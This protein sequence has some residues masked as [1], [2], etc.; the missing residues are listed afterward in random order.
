MKTNLPA[1][2]S[3]TSWIFKAHFKATPTSDWRRLA[4]SFLLS[5]R[6]EEKDLDCRL[7]FY[8]R[9]I[10]QQDYIQF[11]IVIIDYKLSTAGRLRIVHITGSKFF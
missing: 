2:G 7:G 11:N 10:D 6:K 5:E 3:I 4:V 8:Q 1:V 9:E